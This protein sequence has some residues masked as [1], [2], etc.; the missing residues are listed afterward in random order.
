MTKKTLFQGRNLI[1]AF[2]LI[3]LFC[4]NI[5][6]VNASYTTETDLTLSVTTATIG[7]SVILDANVWAG[8]IL[9]PR[10]TVFFS[11][12]D[13]VTY[14]W[15]A[16]VPIEESGPD[17]GHAKYTWD[18]P[19]DWGEGITTLY[20]RYRGND[21]FDPSEDTADITIED[22]RY[23]TS[24]EL[25]LSAVS[26]FPTETITLEAIVQNE[27]TSDVPIGEIQF[28]DDTY[29][30]LLGTV[31]LNAT[32]RAAFSW[33]ISE[34]YPEGLIILKAEYQG[35]SLFNPSEDSKEFTIL[36][37]IIPTVDITLLPDTIVVGDEVH[38]TVTVWSAEIIVTPTGT[39]VFYDEDDTYLGEDIL[40]DAGD[41][42]IDW[43][44]PSRYAEYMGMS[45]TM[46]AEYSGDM[47]FEPS[48]ASTDLEIE[49]TIYSTE[50]D[51]TLSPSTS[52]PGSSIN[53]EAK[54]TTLL[55]E[56]SPEG[57]VVFRDVSNGQ[58][59]GTTSLDSE[60]I[61]SLTWQIPSSQIPQELI[62]R[63]EYLGD[64]Y[65]MFIPSEEEKPLL[66]EP[67]T[68]VMN[69]IVSPSSVWAGADLEILIEVLGVGTT[70]IPQGTIT[71]KDELNDVII[72]TLVL[73]SSATCQKT[74]TIPSVSSGSLEISA[75]YEG[76]SW[77][78]PAI[79]SGYLTVTSDSTAPQ[80]TVNVDEEEI[81]SE[82]VEIHV[83]VS[84][85]TSISKLIVN[86]EEF[87]AAV[88]TYILRTMDYEDG[89]F[90]L[91]IRAIDI[92]DNE[93]ILI[94]KLIID[95]TPPDI[96][97]IGIKDGKLVSG[98]I[99]FNLEAEDTTDVSWFINGKSVQTSSKIDTSALS[100]GKNEFS[101][102]AEDEA[103][104]RSKT[105]VTLRVDNTKPSI[106]IEYDPNTSVMTVLVEDAHLYVTNIYANGTLFKQFMHN[107]D[108]TAE[109]FEV[110][111]GSYPLG[112]Y[113][114]IIDSL[115][116]TNNLGSEQYTLIH[117]ENNPEP[118]SNPLTT[119]ESSNPTESETTTSIQPPNTSH[120]TE[121]PETSGENPPNEQPLNIT[122]T[123]APPVTPEETTTPGPIP[124]V[125]KNSLSTPMIII[126]VAGIAFAA[127]KQSGLLNGG[128]R[129]FSRGGNGRQRE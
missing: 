106:T 76:S 128:I 33:Q 107:K 75:A 55:T 45:V 96:E 122:M 8:T 65:G 73:D 31:S 90:N 83:M 125:S 121:S 41:T 108:K 77:F 35:T 123:N 67:F 39:V 71:L 46:R 95:N 94:R 124:T 28:H 43:I 38:I 34:S 99:K 53:L 44:T 47:Y 14:T 97:N 56:L 1:L 113:S 98:I 9:I 42:A 79:G 21:T 84:D 57:S 36:D 15:S 100:D 30:D 74:W 29:K 103:G 82:T 23:T 40:D 80:I 58:T 127:I 13:F 126:G 7:E 12:G 109:S 120:I 66:V 112:N 78:Y 11:D 60:G 20:A 37:R 117:K 70:R 48:T 129:R 89:Q 62:I 25:L 10:G 59:L 91:V 110:S 64:D 19:E 18:I 115:D 119:S 51:L 5:M 105:S 72:D 63:A 93:A 101:I 68:S 17:I 88:A 22:E 24:C 32:G 86:D 114:I 2:F 26:G 49:E 87:S 6:S 61:A 85:D 52:I 4:G 116:Q 102:R 50:T 3:T 92:A 104:H 81:L 111:F 16:E 27:E 118:S 69:V 54:I